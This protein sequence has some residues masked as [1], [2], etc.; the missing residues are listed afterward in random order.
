MECTETVKHLLFLPFLPNVSP[1]GTWN[2]GAD[3]TLGVPNEEMEID[4]EGGNFEWKTFLS[5][6]FPTGFCSKVLD[7]SQIQQ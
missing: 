2:K 3:P 7:R 6:Y 5:P 4:V 1:R